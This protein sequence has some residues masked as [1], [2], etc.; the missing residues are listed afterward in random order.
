MINHGERDRWSRWLWGSA[1]GMRK[2]L[3]GA[4]SNQN[5]TKRLTCAL[6][7]E[8]VAPDGWVGSA[9]ASITMS[10]VS[11]LPYRYHY[12]PTYYG[13]QAQHPLSSGSDRSLLMSR[14][15]RA[16][17]RTGTASAARLTPVV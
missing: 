11:C 1:V 10:H 3:I 12:F 17:R 8:K 15:G 6:A 14:S 5:Y 9:P 16:S 13:S 2:A 4:G 7:D